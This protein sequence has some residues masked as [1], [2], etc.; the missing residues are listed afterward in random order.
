[1][2]R[3]VLLLAVFLGWSVYSH[4]TNRS[5]PRLR[6]G[7]RPDAYPFPTGASH[8]GID[9]DDES[10]VRGWCASL[11]CTE[12]QLRAAVRRA[13]SSVEAVREHLARPR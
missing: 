11:D 7:S 10:A 2:Q 8:S 1:M 3:V 6:Y 13:G 9:I 5:R 12:E 4:S